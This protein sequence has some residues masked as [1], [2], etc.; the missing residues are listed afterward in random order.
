MKSL[1]MAEKIFSESI[2]FKEKIFG[3]STQEKRKFKSDVYLKLE[4]NH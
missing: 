4:V 1:T 2:F 3:L